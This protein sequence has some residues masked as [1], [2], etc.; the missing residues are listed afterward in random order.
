MTEGITVSIGIQ[1]RTNSTR[2]PNKAMKK[3][4]GVPTVDHVANSA[5]KSSQYINRF[6][7]RTGVRS[8]VFILVPEGDPLKEYLEGRPNISVLE[9]PEDDL[10]GRYN[11][12]MKDNPDYV[13]R[14]TGDCPLLPPFLITKCINTAIQNKYDFLDNANPEFRCFYDGA[15]VE[16]M[17]NKA[18]NWVYENA[19]EREHVC[20][21]LRQEAP[22]HLSFGHVFSFLDL[23]AFKLSIDTAKDFDLV[24]N[25]Y[26]SVHNKRRKWE[27]RYGKGSAHMF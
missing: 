19:K 21:S 18:F 17:S 24:N 4:L 27:E 8:R 10:I 3:I 6:S 12:L 26:K 25:Q 15:D 20:H 1:A 22:E 7:D 11:L 5:L 2:L 14:L 13:V 16:V 9:G 23:S